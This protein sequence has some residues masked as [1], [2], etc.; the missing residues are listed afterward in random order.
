MNIAA[1][2]RSVSLYS[3]LYSGKCAFRNQATFTNN[4]YIPSYRKFFH[5][6]PSERY[7]QASVYVRQTETNELRC[8]NNRSA[9]LEPGCRARLSLCGTFMLKPT[10]CGYDV[11]KAG[12]V[13]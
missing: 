2:R 11:T 5:E 9:S 8:R 13:A 7:H 3:F 12:T 1:V 4:S 6:K 10:P